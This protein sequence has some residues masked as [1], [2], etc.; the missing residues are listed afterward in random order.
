MGLPPIDYLLWIYQGGG[1]AIYD[2]AYGK[3]GMVYLVTGVTPM[4]CGLRSNKPIKTLADLKGMK[5]RM[6]GMHQGKILKDL[7]AAQGAMAGQE[8]DQA[9]QKGVIEAAEVSSPSSDWGMGFGEVTKYW[10]VPGWHQPASVMGVMINKKVWDKLTPDLQK[11]LKY[12]AKAAA[13]E[14]TTKQYYDGIEFT[15]KFIKKGI[16]IT[17][18]DDEV[19]NTIE[20]LAAKHTAESAKQ[21]PLFKKSIESQMKFRKAFERWRDMEGQFGFGFNPT[22]YPDVK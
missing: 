15:N 18:Y 21:S 7:G 2:E 8:S 11:D 6:S 17:T 14:F 4:E 19:M 12:A 13:L 1:Q 22:V 16:K 10:A 5:I 20:K 3:F 9:L